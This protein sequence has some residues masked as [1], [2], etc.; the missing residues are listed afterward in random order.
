MTI[1]TVLKL[2]LWL[3]GFPK[4]FP[5]SVLPNSAVIIRD[6]HLTDQYQIST[7]L[8]ST[9]FPLDWPVPN[10]HLTGQYQIST[11]LAS[12]KFPLDWPVPNFH[13]TGQYQI[14][15]WLAS[16]KF[17]LDWPVPNLHL[18]GQYQIST[19]LAST[20]FCI[21]FWHSAFSFSFTVHLC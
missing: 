8:T 14:S 19:W 12:T 13:L 7:W 17:P 16:T 10:F 21:I 1:G 6:F 2:E 11:W 20:K 9:K 18:T 15:T 4:S 3:T 5:Q